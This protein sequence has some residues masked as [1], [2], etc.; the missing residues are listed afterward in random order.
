MSERDG[1]RPHRLSDDQLE[2][3]SRHLLLPGFGAAQQR[4]LAAAQVLVVGAGGLGSASIPYLIAAGVGLLTV[5]D[6]DVVEL[7]NLQR[8]ILHRTADVGEPKAASA[9]RWA[10]AL[11]P[12]DVTIDPRRERLDATNVREL[13]RAADVVIDG[14]DNF[15]TRYLIA[16]ACA[17]EQR[18][19][20]HGAVF[21]WEGQASTFLPGGGRF[22]GH[23]R[24]DGGGSTGV[25]DG[26]EPA[27]LVDDATVGDRPCYRCLFPEPP[28]A[29][30][31]PSCAEAGVLGAVVGAIGVVQAIEAIKVITRLGEPL[32]GRLMVFDAWSM[33]WRTIRYRRAESCPM[34]GSHA[35]IRD[36]IPIDAAIDVCDARPLE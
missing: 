25:D 15:A 29:G 26:G 10:E 17:L 18:A 3:Y 1:A 19:L 36:I 32:V 30:T 31:V 21:R 4:A 28:P 12:G 9:A 33:T 2:R 6:S 8:Q 16:D 13:V 35:S 14:T 7:S 27:T 23:D 34:C 24:G 11:N 5:V 20:C 22:A